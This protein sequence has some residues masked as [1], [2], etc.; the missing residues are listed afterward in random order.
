MGG[1]L[2]DLANQS[3]HDVPASMIDKP[4]QI[5]VA[6]D[7]IP[8]RL[9]L[10]AILERQGFAVL[11]ADTGQEAV[12]IYAQE[13]PDLILM[14]IKMPVMDGY[15]ATRRIKAMS[16]DSFVP[17]IFLTATSDSEGL[18]KCIESGGDDFL[19]KPYNHVL[20]RARIDALL[21]IR[22]LYNTVHQQR[23]ELASH[24]KRL[25]Q[26]RQ[27]AKRVFTNIVDTGA[28]DLPNI[29][30]VLSPL[31]L[32]S[33]DIL[34]AA[35]KPSGGLHVLL[36]DFTGHGLAAATGALPVSSVFYGMTAKGYSIGEIVSEINGKLKSILPT[37]MFLAACMVDMNPSA[38]TL[39]I[40]NGGIPPVLI[41]GEQEKAI[42]KRVEPRHLPLG[43]ADD[44]S[45]NRRVDV[46]EM[47]QGDRAYISSD[48]VTEAVN[49]DGE[50]FGRER[51]EAVLNSDQ[52]PDDLFECLRV[53][54]RSHQH[55]VEQHDDVALI[56]LVY[57][58]ELLEVI[59]NLDG[60]QE[61]SAGLPASHW[62]L[63]LDLSADL[64]RH[65]DPLPLLIQSICDMQGFRG[66]RQ[67]LFTVLSELYS[68][69][70]DH[71]ILGL[72]STLKSTADGFSKFYNERATKLA[73]LTEGSIQI[74]IQHYPLEQGGG[75]LIVRIEDSGQGFDYESSQV[76]LEE[77]QG[78][79]GRGVH[80]LRSICHE[81]R[82]EGKGNIVEVTYRWR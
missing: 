7:D 82:Y 60:A 3:A 8:N 29:K 67:Q 41:Y 64:I 28:L 22:E 31:S 63:S 78:H 30:S 33:G 72:D 81:V 1:L 70:L 20:L 46:V 40:W 50:M 36:G 26:E 27:L 37:N 21:R 76:S 80:L 15:E 25:D 52:Q 59:V 11:Q 13:R 2:S 32:F 79:S 65:F 47:R 19:T 48:G 62:D 39:S 5:L 44:S 75:E 61:V 16:G 38:H 74:N 14:D 56:E 12:D 10:Q 57:D 69:A 45:F 9:V 34:L 49:A 18:V 68:N 77:N 42:I 17:V 58:Q 6:D 71:G 55:G 23:D 66:Q 43:I 54:L 51:L 35:P 53:D 4:L 73:A 24:Q